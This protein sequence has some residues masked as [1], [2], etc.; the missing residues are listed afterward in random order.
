[1]VLPVIS[2]VIALAACGNLGA[3][4]PLSLDQRV[5]TAA[6]A[7]GTKPDPEETREQTA[8]FDEFIVAMKDRAIDPEA[9]MTD[10]FRNAGFKAAI[11][12]A[13][14]FGDVHSH[15]VPHLFTSVIQLASQEGAESALDWLHSDSL[16]PCPESCAVQ[17]S[18]FDVDGIQGALGVR[19]AQSAE[20]I[21]NLGRPGDEPFESY[22]VLFVDGSFTYSM[23]LRGQP[24]AVTEKQAET[25]AL[26]LYKRVRG[27]PPPS[28]SGAAAES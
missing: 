4:Q 12:D 11:A 19:R 6:D 25:I 22:E 24:G 10:V 23:V 20:D 13:R 21:K 3:T 18:E 1:M 7:P 8:D 17:I 15:D 5:A 14:F 28:G 2:S 16:K 26:A 9:S 27:A